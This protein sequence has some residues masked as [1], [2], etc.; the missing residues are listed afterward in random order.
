LLLSA[1]R[2]SE[3]VPGYYQSSLTGLPTPGASAGCLFFYFVQRRR[4]NGSP[5]RLPR[6]GSV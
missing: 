6:D 4:D 3:T 1:T 5:L 2:A